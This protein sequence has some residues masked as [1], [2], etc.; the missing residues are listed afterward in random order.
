MAQRNPHEYPGT[1]VSEYPPPLTHH[2]SSSGD[3]YDVEKS[4][5]IGG[6][7]AYDVQLA[8]ARGDGSNISGGH[9]KRQLKNRHSESTIKFAMVSG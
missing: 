8:D 3:D 2:K 4:K 7:D 6:G 9:L 5:S 1:P